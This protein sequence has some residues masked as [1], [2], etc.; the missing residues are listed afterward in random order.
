MELNTDKLKN[1]ATTKHNRPCKEVYRSGAI[2]GTIFACVAL[3]FVYLVIIGAI[4]TIHIAEKLREEGSFMGISVG[5]FNMLALWFA[6]LMGIGAAIIS[7][8]L[9]ANSIISYRKAVNVQNN[10]EI[11]KRPLIFSI[12]SA[13][14]AGLSCVAIIIT[15]VVFYS[16]L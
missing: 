6:V 8:L 14:L 9:C 15:M 5:V 4:D 13:V 11:S 2:V 7:G 3:F 1:S 12:V 10:V 16:V